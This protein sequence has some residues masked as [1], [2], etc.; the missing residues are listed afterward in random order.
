MDSVSYVHLGEK[1]QIVVDTVQK[2]KSTL[3]YKKKRKRNLIKIKTIA[4]IG[5][6]NFS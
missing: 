4:F 3:I 5:F 2:F 6:N 1:R